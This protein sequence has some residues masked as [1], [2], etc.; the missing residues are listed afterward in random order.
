MD[1]VIKATFDGAVFRPTEPVRLLPNT[2]VE[3]TVKTLPA[4]PPKSASFLR[5]A[6]SL[7]IQGPPDWSENLGKYLYGEEPSSDR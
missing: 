4:P 6:R 5:V 1:T 3:L 7:K 2:S